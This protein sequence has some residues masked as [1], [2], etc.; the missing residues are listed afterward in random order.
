MEDDPRLFVLPATVHSGTVLKPLQRAASETGDAHSISA[1]V[2]MDCRSPQDGE[3]IFNSCVHAMHFQCWK[4]AMGSGIES[5]THVL[6][7][8]PLCRSYST[9]VLP[10]TTASARLLLNMGGDGAAPA[11]LLEQGLT[12]LS[13]V[14]FASALESALE[15]ATLQ[16]LMNLPKAHTDEIAAYSKLYSRTVSSCMKLLLDA[17]ALTPPRV[18]SPPKYECHTAM[19][20]WRSLGQTVAG[21]ENADRTLLADRVLPPTTSKSL[22]HMVSTTLAVTCMSPEDDHVESL[23]AERERLLALLD[24][25]APLDTD[26]DRVAAATSDPF[27]T[28]V[29]AVMLLAMEPQVTLLLKVQRLRAV[30]DTA[31]AD[32]AL[33]AGPPTT[34]LPVAQL[35]QTCLEL[36][37]LSDVAQIVLDSEVLAPF[38]T[39][40]DVHMASAE[41][42]EALGA[43]VRTLQAQMRQDDSDAAAALQQKLTDPVAV[44][45]LLARRWSYLRCAVL[46]QHVLQ[47]A[48]EEDSG[49][50]R[51]PATFSAAAD[52]LGLPTFAELA[53]DLCSVRWESGG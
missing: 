13:E 41:D 43:M 8:C 2:A 33:R 52:V 36:A 28:L 27:S 20:L 6:F 40:D 31:A 14:S 44:N 1:V 47:A 35:V 45:W 11:D 53:V 15:P 49:I 19:L 46:F 25:R 7:S 24:S 51:L 17:R 21:I 5:R 34:T 39:Q 12:R 37:L 42:C 50:K 29:S 23:D 16:L 30:G 26:A 32:A 10:V 9:I 38:E 3:S 18:A 48:S 22:R 4:Q